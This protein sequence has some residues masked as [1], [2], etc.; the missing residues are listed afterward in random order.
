MLKDSLLKTSAALQEADARSH[1]G[2]W[3]QFWPKCSN[4]ATEKVEKWLFSQ[5]EAAGCVDWR[6]LSKWMDF[7]LSFFRRKLVVGITQH[8]SAGGVLGLAGKLHIRCARSS[9]FQPFHENSHHCPMEIKFHII[10]KLKGDLSYL[11]KQ[12]HTRIML[13][14]SLISESVPDQNGH[15][16]TIM[17]KNP[18]LGK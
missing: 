5:I 6:P 8:L 17:N 3:L 7:Q 9:N 14:R 1:F 15:W 4:A 16:Y 2:S 12:V 18:V 13:L 10:V 11:F